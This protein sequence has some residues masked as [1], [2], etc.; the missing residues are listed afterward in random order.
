LRE[1]LAWRLS[2][3]L[4]CTLTLLLCTRARAGV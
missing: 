1:R 2:L 3:P 4:R